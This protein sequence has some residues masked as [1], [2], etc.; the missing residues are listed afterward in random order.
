[1]HLQSIQASRLYAVYP[2]SHSSVTLNFLYFELKKCLA[3]FNVILGVFK[4]KCLLVIVVALASLHISFKQNMR[5]HICI[6][7]VMTFDFFS[8]VQMFRFLIKCVIEK[9]F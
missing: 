2:L 8:I 3:V 4:E 9:G 5:P 1:M 6:P 7:S